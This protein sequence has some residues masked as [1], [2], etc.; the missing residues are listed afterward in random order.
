MTL[1]MP[2][3]SNGGG[4]TLLTQV[5]TFLSDSPIVEM[6]AVLNPSEANVC[7]QG[8]KA[9]PL[10][11]ALLNKH[12]QTLGNTSKSNRTERDATDA[13]VDVGNDV[14]SDHVICNSVA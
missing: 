12:S 10:S 3:G 4:L 11:N 9:Q 1:Q 8:G 2:E 7:N 14:M 13:I 6:A 5:L